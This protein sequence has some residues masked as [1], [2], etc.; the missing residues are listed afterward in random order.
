MAIFEPLQEG[1]NFDQNQKSRFKGPGVLAKRV[2]SKSRS[3]LVNILKVESSFWTIL[4][5]NVSVVELICCF[6]QTS[7]PSG[8]INNRNV[9]HSP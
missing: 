8:I 6:S 9:S 2:F 4:T 7:W 5:P 1:S 3:T